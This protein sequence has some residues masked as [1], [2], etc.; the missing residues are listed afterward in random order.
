VALQQSKQKK[1]QLLFRMTDNCGNDK[2][3]IEDERDRTTLQSASFDTDKCLSC[4]VENSQ[5][6]S[7][8]HTSELQ[9]TPIS[10]MPSSA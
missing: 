7:E 8:E 2:T 4:V 5:T 6:R 1:E 3:R 10:R 9:V